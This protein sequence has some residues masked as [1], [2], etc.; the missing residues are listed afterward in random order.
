MATRYYRVPLGGSVK[1]DVT[2]AASS[3]LVWVEV[4]CVYDL[5]GNSKIEFLN[6]LEAVRQYVL[7]D[8]WPPNT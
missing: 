3:S 4:Q 1:Q 2:E 8:A 5:S 6:A 7:G